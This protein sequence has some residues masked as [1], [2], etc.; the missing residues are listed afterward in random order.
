MARQFTNENNYPHWLYH[1]LTTNNYSKGTR[2]SD[3]SVTRLIDSP[4]VNQ[5]RFEHSN[6][7]IEDVKDRVWSIWG[8]AVH[9]V[10][11]N[12]NESNSDVLTEKRFYND[13]DGKVVTGQIDVYDMSS[14]ILYDVKTV[15]AWNLVNGHKKSWEYQLN[16]LADIMIANAWKV[17]GLA[18]VAVARDWNARQASE[19]E[20]YP[21]HAMTVVDIPLWIPSIRKKYIDQQLSRHFKEKHYCSPEERWQSEEKWAVMK[22]GRKNALRLTDSEEEANKYIMDLIDPTKAYIEHR[23]GSPKRCWSYCNVRNFCPQ[24]RAERQEKR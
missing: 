14:K 1:T 3:I 15:S 4:Q 24:L 21:N 8:S 10:V 7:L 6:E 20:A 9:S 2:P 13:Y 16:V 19:K 18:I 5:L 22:D 17:K 23:E 12:T 11:E